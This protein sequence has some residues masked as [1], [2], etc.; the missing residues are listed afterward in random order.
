[1][2]VSDKGGEFVVMSQQ[3]DRSIVQ[4]HLSDESVYEVTDS[5]SYRKCV[6]LINGTWLTVGKR[7]NINDSLIKRLSST[8]PSPPVIYTLVK[9]HKITQDK[10]SSSDPSTIKVRPIISACG[11]PA[12]KISWLLV[13]ILSPLLSCVPA[14]LFNTYQ[15]IERLNSFDLPDGASF[16]SFDV[17]SLYTNVDNPGAIAAVQEL[18]N[19]NRDK[20]NLFGLSTADVILLLNTIIR[21]NIFAWSG[22]YYRQKRGLAMGNRI[23]PILAIAFMN[24]LE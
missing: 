24:H 22:C 12:D 9:A 17:E 21:S 18:I 11:G 3:L 20:V 1:M 2:T 13:Q 15:F 6:D 14:H 4:L 5:K 16:C 7:C 10:L 23:A 8:H 19:A